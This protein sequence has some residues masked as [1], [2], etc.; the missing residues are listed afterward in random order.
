MS[1]KDVEQ[2]RR[3]LVLPGRECFAARKAG[4]LSSHLVMYVC[5]VGGIGVEH[6]GE[7]KGRERKGRE[8]KVSNGVENIPGVKSG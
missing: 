7:G 3:G 4:S 5:G 8:R 6:E 1:L 2:T